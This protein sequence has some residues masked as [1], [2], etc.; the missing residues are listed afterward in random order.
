MEEGQPELEDEHC[1]ADGVHDRTADGSPNVSRQLLHNLEREQEL[2]RGTAPFHATACLL[3]QPRAC[4]DSSPR[5]QPER[6]APR[7]QLL[8]GAGR[9]ASRSGA[10]RS[11]PSAPAAASEPEG[12]GAGN[13]LHQ[14]RLVDLHER[15]L[16]VRGMLEVWRVRAEVGVE[17]DGGEVAGV[18]GPAVQDELGGN[19]E[20]AVTEAAAVDIAQARAIEVLVEREPEV[21]CL[22]DHLDRVRLPPAPALSLVLP[23]Q[24]WR[25]TALEEEVRVTRG[26]RHHEQRLAQHREMNIPHNHGDTSRERVDIPANQQAHSLFR[27]L[28]RPEDPRHV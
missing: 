5:S 26:A 3:R 9:E 22:P 28:L 11:P 7:S 17:G 23:Q 4:L 27:A 14:V 8:A 6:R 18:A 12:G 25:P 13:L 2:A 15:L 1:D 10:S 24:T 16:K 20:H 19:G 21:G